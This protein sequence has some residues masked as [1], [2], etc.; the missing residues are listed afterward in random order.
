MLSMIKRPISFGLKGL[1]CRPLLAVL[2]LLLAACGGVAADPQANGE[3]GG[4]EVVSARSAL[5]A[6]EGRLDFPK[7]EEL[8]FGIAGTVGEITVVS[9]QKVSA[10]EDLAV[11]DAATLSRLEKAHAQQLVALDQAQKNLEDFKRGLQQDEALANQIEAQAALANDLAEQSLNAFQFDFDLKLAQ[12]IKIQA[13]AEL[14]LDQAKEDL[15]DFEL[16]SARELAQAQQQ[17]AAADLA[18]DRALEVLANLGLDYSQE[19]ASAL[20]VLADTELAAGRAE[21]DLADFQRDYQQALATARRVTADAELALEQALDDLADHSP[22]RADDLAKAL[23]AKVDAEDAVRAARLAFDDFEGGRTAQLALVNQTVTEA[24]QDHNDAADAL[25]E[26]I[27]EQVLAPNP[28]SNVSIVLAELQA[29]E[30]S[31][32]DA[33]TLSRSDLTSLSLITGTLRCRDFRSEPLLDWCEQLTTGMEL[34]QANLDK[35]KRDL[36]DLQDPTGS[37]SETK[38]Q[39]TLELQQLQA[40]VEVARADFNSAVNDQDELEE[41]PDALERS[42]LASGVEVTAAAL[43]SA[44]QALD[45]TRVSINS[46]AIDRQRRA[47]EAATVQVAEAEA[48]LASA[49]A[50]GDPVELQAKMDSLAGGQARLATE[51]KALAAMESGA[52]PLEIASVESKVRL[53]TEDLTGATREVDRLSIGPDP[54]KRAVLEASLEAANSAL[55]HAGDDLS[56]LLTGQDKMELALREKKVQLTSEE[57]IGATKKSRK[58]ARELALGPEAVDLGLLEAQVAQTISALCDARE[59][60]DGATI[61]APFSGTVSRINVDPD[62]DVNDESRILEIIDQSV[63]EVRGAVDGTDI[64]RVQAGASAQVTIDSIPGR[65]FTGEVTF[66]ATA[67]RTERG[68]VTYPVVV[69]VDLPQALEA[70]LQMSPVSVDVIAGNALQ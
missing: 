49:K 32:S 46:G 50:A 5:I 6:V 34:A 47:T 20:Q 67:P 18:L 66:V 11:L 1:Y 10:G 62:D 21:E 31:T 30:V 55:A 33:L 35:A 63:V 70:P 17:R 25:N 8:K 24:T 27:V 15:V 7:R 14:D 56:I 44:R 28:P 51:Q 59:D 64:L 16:D 2:L 65:E 43:K 41:G 39:E 58:L 4:S 68:V 22:T 37:N 9:G 42:R 3:S 13:E 29:I 26:Y 38:G 52:D 48:A 45:D 23:Q 57:L 12:A 60:L 53:L 54:L 36:G 40:K 19:L 61:R 69:R